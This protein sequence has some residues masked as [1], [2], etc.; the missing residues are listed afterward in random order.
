MVFPSRP[1]DSVGGDVTNVKFEE[2]GGLDVVLRGEMSEM[3][4]HGSP[5]VRVLMRPDVTGQADLEAECAPAHPFFVKG[6]GDDCSSAS[7]SIIT[8]PL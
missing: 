5:R 3:R 6:K 2:R 7:Q 8:L 1:T 4:E